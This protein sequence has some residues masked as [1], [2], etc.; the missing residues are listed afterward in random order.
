M[1]IGPERLRITIILDFVLE[2]AYTA[3]DFLLLA[4]TRE[5]NKKSANLGLHVSFKLV[6]LYIGTNPSHNYTKDMS[7]ALFRFEICLAFSANGLRD[8]RIVGTEE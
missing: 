1:G 7:V 2:S 4:F 8:E 5:H 3:L 6:I